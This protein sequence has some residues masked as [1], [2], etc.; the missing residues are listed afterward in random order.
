MTDI[1]TLQWYLKETFEFPIT[2]FKDI[3]VSIIQS[4]INAEQNLINLDKKFTIRINDNMNYTE[5]IKS[6]INNNSMN[7]HYLFSDFK[8]IKKI[9]SIKKIDS[10]NKYTIEYE[11]TFYTIEEF[12]RYELYKVLEMNIKFLQCPVCGNFF[13]VEHKNSIY[14]STKCRQKANNKKL[15]NDP[16]FSVYN[17]KRKKI[18]NYHYSYGQKANDKKT[19]KD[20]KP[21]KDIYKKY[22]QPLDEKLDEKNY[23]KFLEEIER[24]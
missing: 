2:R 12:C 9:N 17:Q 24:Y 10:T 21:L 15:K 20:L 7:L 6:R 23:K 3:Y 5:T 8:S 18:L 13:V 11:S 4:I 16:Y 19:Q 14:C 22:K 1:N